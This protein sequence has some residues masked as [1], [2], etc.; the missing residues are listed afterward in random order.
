M[1]FVTTLAF[2]L[3]F[4]AHLCSAETPVFP[5]MDEC[6]TISFRMS[7]G[8]WVNVEHDGSGAYG[9]GALPDRISLKPS[10]FDFETIY[11]WAKNHLDEQKP[12]AELP[13][14]TVSCY[15]RM[16]ENGVTFHIT[17]RPWVLDLFRMARANAVKPKN[18]AEDRQHK[19][20]DHFWEKSS[21]FTDD[22]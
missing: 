13:S 8:W 10:S 21:F 17:D 5:A 12:H 18:E 4:S 22:K 9:F 2:I 6:D 20:I 15:R 16:Q 19:K 11:R 1:P 14:I 7:E 3:A